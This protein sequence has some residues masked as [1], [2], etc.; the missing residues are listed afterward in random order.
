VIKSKVDFPHQTVAGVVALSRSSIPRGRAHEP[1]LSLRRMRYHGYRSQASIR[2]NQHGKVERPSEPKVLETGV[3]IVKDWRSNKR[4]T[5]GPTFK[6]ARRYR[7]VF[8]QPVVKQFRGSETDLRI[9]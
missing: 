8:V 6:P 1:E 4:K 2:K 9:H 7:I 5:L 3:I